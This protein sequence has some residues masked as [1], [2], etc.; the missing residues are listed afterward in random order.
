MRF[1]KFLSPAP[2]FYI[3]F[4]LRD[5]GASFIL[6]GLKPSKHLK[7]AEFY[8]KYV[9]ETC[10]KFLQPPLS[11]VPALSRTLNNYRAE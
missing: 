7:M 2:L 11:A 9:W 8:R 4:Q 1:L 3:N 5:R 6:G 10:L